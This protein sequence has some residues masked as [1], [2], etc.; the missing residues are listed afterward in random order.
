MARVQTS[1]RRGVVLEC[2]VELGAETF[3][4]VYFNALTGKTSYALIHLG[5][6][7]AGFDNYQD[8]HRHPFGADDQHIPVR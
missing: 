4:A 1:E 7:M 6:R 2:R 8:W 5:Q 3:I